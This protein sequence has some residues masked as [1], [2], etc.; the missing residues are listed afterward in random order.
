MKF[1]TCPQEDD[2]LVREPGTQAIIL[3]MLTYVKKFVQRT[4]RIL[5]KENL[6]T[7]GKSRKGFIEEVTLELK[8][9]DRET[10][11]QTGRKVLVGRG[12]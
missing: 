10:D 5:R 4:K 12:H 9:E 3:D 1:R 6:S 7:F 2:N 11:R 8:L